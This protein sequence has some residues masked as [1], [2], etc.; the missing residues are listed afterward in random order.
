M[1]IFSV[2]H[3]KTGTTS[4]YTLINSFGIRSTHQGIIAKPH[5][6]RP[7][8]LDNP[9][10]WAAAYAESLVAFTLSP[11][12]IRF[13]VSWEYSYYI[14]LVSEYLP[15]SIWFIM[16]R[17][18]LY[19]CNS[20]KRYAF[21]SYK[22]ITIFDLCRHYT[23][24]HLFILEQLQYLKHWPWIYYLDF[25]KYIT[26]EYTAPLM[27]MFQV[28]KTSDNLQIAADVLSKKIRSAG[29][30]KVVDPVKY[31]RHFVQGND[32]IFD[33]GRTVNRLIMKTIP[34]LA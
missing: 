24:M 7:Y 29:E 9:P 23:E 21:H 6:S 13:D 22:E 1:N 27:R 19:V 16:L 34:E 18:P 17:D 10:Q 5:R 15:E 14:K 30:Y 28:E 20:L 11:D 8:D 25:D 33:E 3:S 26:G 4:I 31:R 2:G 32:S 12:P